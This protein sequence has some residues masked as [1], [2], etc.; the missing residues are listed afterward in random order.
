MK[1]LDVPQSGSLAG[2]TSSRNRF[3]QYRRTRA[4]PVNPSS[5]AQQAVRT[6]LAERSGAWRE[7]TDAQRQGWETLGALMQ[8][9]DALG[10]VYTLTGFQAFLSVNNNLDAAGDATVEDAPGLIAPSPIIDLV[11]TLA[12]DAFSLDW[13]PTPLGAGER[14]FIYASKQR[15]QGR[16]F[17]HDYRLLKVGAA[18]GTAPQDILAD[19]TAR[20]GAPVLGNRVFV[21]V[22]R[23]KGGFLSGASQGSAVVAAGTP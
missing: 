3:G 19:Y 11:I 16:A 6:R 15:S 1:I 20:F 7:L 17:E 13:S 8:R 22:H 23:Y 10:Q 18:A 14:A 4:V 5:T 9:A 12:E 21:A 2:Q